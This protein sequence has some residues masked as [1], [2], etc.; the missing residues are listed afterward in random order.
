[1]IVV[2]NGLLLVLATTNSTFLRCNMSN[3][4]AFESYAV[5]YVMLLLT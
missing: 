3:M 1:M 4:L 2:V 5:E